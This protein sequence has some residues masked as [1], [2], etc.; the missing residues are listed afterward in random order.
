M[1]A[2][3]KNELISEEVRLLRRLEELLSLIPRATLAGRLDEILRDK[4]HRLL[5]Q[6]TGRIPVKEL[7]KKTGLSTGTI[8]SLWQKWEQTGLIV[9]EGKQYRKVL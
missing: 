1:A 2:G 6:E 9:K 3:D 8:S 4:S 5:Y 7:A